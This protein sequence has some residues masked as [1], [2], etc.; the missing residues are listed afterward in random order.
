MPLQG[1]KSGG[2][3]DL[4][5]NGITLV[6]ALIVGCQGYNTEKETVKMLLQESWE[7]SLCLGLR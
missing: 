1:V 2:G 3:S 5:Y 4:Y 6:A 7:S